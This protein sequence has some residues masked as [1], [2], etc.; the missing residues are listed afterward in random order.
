MIYHNRINHGIGWEYSDSRERYDKRYNKREKENIN[1]KVVEK[2]Q[3][4]K[5]EIEMTISLK[6]RERRKDIVNK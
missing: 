4:H 5:K 3:G 6:L 1:L 2:W